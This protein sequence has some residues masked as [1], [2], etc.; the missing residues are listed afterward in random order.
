MKTAISIRYGGLFVDAS[1]CDYTSFKHQGLLC[2][3]CKKT[4]FLV[5]GSER[6]PHQRTLKNGSVREVKKAKIDAYFA[7]HPDTEKASV[8]ACE[9]RSSQITQAQKQLVVAQSRGQRLK[10]LQA[11]CW[12][13][14]KTS[15]KL[16]DIDTTP[17]L[18]YSFWER[19]TSHYREP[20]AAKRMYQLLIDNLCDQFRLSAQLAHTK[21]TLGHGIDRWV[22]DS[23]DE[24][25]V[26]PAMKPLFELWRSQLDR[27]MQEAITCEVLD[28]ISQVRQKP[29]LQAL[30]E[31]GVYNFVLCSSAALQARITDLSQLGRYFNKMSVDCDLADESMIENMIA[32]TTQLSRL[33][34]D[35]FEACFNYVRDDVVQSIVFT[36]WAG[37]FQRLE[38]LELSGIDRK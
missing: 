7:H 28:F 16:A 17:K 32:F 34:N 23:Q 18:L 37:E 25:L 13:I 5:S 22:K 6:S 21:S 33:N 35:Q 8:E 30:V 29:I 3:I 9:L 31:N 27:K 11:H 12:K 38:N 2:P 20:K 26:V 4:V 24:F 36:D 15:I 14:L 1:E 19:A 10:I